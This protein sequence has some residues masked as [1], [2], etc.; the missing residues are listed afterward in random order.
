MSLI[1]LTPAKSTGRSPP[2]PAWNSSL[3][4]SMMSPCTRTLCEWVCA[5]SD[6]WLTMRDRR[7]SSTSMIEV[8]SGGCM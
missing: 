5:G 1:L 6:T 8:P 2:T 7:G 3:L 4:T